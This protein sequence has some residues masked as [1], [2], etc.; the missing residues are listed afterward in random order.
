LQVVQAEVRGE[1]RRRWS[2]KNSR[3]RRRRGWGVRRW[4]GLLLT[5]GVA[6]RESVGV[7]KGVGLRGVPRRGP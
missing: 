2:K 3:R 5:K 4:E 1:G 6:V 7:A